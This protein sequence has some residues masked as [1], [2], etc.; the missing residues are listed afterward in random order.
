MSRNK[1][2]PLLYSGDIMLKCIMYVVYII[3]FNILSAQMRYSETPGSEDMVIDDDEPIYDRLTERGG[4]GD[5][6]KSPRL[7]QSHKRADSQSYRRVRG[8]H[9][10]KPNRESVLNLADD[11][12]ERN[13]ATQSLTYHPKPMEH[14]VAEVEMTSSVKISSSVELPEHKPHMAA[15]LAPHHRRTNSKDFKKDILEGKKKPMIE[16]TAPITPKGTV[17]KMT[18]KFSFPVAQGTSIPAGGMKGSRIQTT[19]QGNSPLKAMTSASEMTKS[20]IPVKLRAG[21]SKVLSTNDVANSP[22][23]NG[24]LALQHKV[25]LRSSDRK[26]TGNKP[27]PASLDMSLLLK[28]ERNMVEQN[29]D[30][31]SSNNN[32]QGD[33]DSETNSFHRNVSA[34]KAFRRRS[35]SRELSPESAPEDMKALSE[36]ELVSETVP[37]SPTTG[38]LISN[39]EA[40][41]FVSDEVPEFNEM[42][43]LAHALEEEEKK[44]SQNTGSQSSQDSIRN[45]QLTVRERTQRW[46]ARGGGLPSYFSTLPKSFRHRATDQRKDPAYIRYMQEYMGEYP[47]DTCMDN[48]ETMKMMMVMSAT[49]MNTS[50]NSGGGSSKVYRSSRSSTSSHGSQP[51]GIPL[52][53]SRIRSPRSTLPGTSQATPNSLGKVVTASTTGVGRDYHHNSVS[54]ETHESSPRH[55]YHHRMDSAD[56]GARGLNSSGQSPSSNENSLERRLGEEQAG[57]SPLKES[58]NLMTGRKSGS[59]VREHSLLFR[60]V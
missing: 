15:P 10:S 58:S 45:L 21:D 25:P 29:Q 1:L 14:T 59:Q 12:M 51:S 48:E 46:E 17:S 43:A 4:R 50:A 23:R 20:G 41:Q 26:W 5:G 8:T 39:S 35:Q 7:P 40:E 9:S 11:L 32:A 47:G 13:F 30:N 16:V 27:R 52:P 38:A 42:S 56:D 33:S 57:A 37:R 31:F 22:V 6:P 2:G 60:S 3:D 55:H 19:R 24:G 18:K 49:N 54:P 53:I 28:N 36:P 34:R 44:L